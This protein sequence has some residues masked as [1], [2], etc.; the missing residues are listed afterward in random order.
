VERP[1][2]TEVY[3]TVL[4]ADEALLPRLVTLLPPPSVP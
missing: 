3:R 1:Q 4:A 2:W